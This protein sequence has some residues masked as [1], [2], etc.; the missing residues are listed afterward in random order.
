MV[1]ALAATGVANDITEHLLEVS[2]II[3][4]QM[5]VVILVF[6]NPKFCQRYVLNM[7]N[8]TGTLTLNFSFS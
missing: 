7:E 6:A 1:V 4:D 5:A 3:F 2:V 8:E